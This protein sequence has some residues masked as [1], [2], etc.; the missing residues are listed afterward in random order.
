MCS[1]SVCIY[2]PLTR[3]FPFLVTLLG[4]LLLFGQT[5][6]VSAVGLDDHFLSLDQL[7]EE[8]DEE[9]DEKEGE[10]SEKT[11]VD[12][13]SQLHKPFPWLQEA[14]TEERVFFSCDRLLPLFP[15]SFISFP[16]SSEQDLLVERAAQWAFSSFSALWQYHVLLHSD[17]IHQLLNTS[18]TSFQTD[19]ESTEED[20][21]CS[22]V[23]AHSIYLLSLH[24]P[25]RSEHSKGLLSHSSSFLIH[26]GDS[27]VRDSSHTCILGH[28]SLLRPPSPLLAFSFTP[29]L[30]PGLSQSFPA[31]IQGF[32]LLLA[33]PSSA[34]LPVPKAALHALNVSFGSE[35]DAHMLMEFSEP[36]SFLR[37]D[38]CSLHQWVRTLLLPCLRE[39]VCVLLVPG[40]D[41]EGESFGR[42]MEQYQAMFYLHQAA[43]R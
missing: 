40:E 13:S 33:S 16:P 41:S 37:E 43:L 38:L 4:C 27:A 25:P 15:S 35:D 39:E 23:T 32:C 3:W 9:E 19:P 26:F 8:D 22:I 20:C 2:Y 30:H 21:H 17:H 34:C 1:L 11:L 6:D 24:L 42:E 29:S 14:S 36:L 18:L 10:F 12:T 5:A 31:A 28:V 7:E